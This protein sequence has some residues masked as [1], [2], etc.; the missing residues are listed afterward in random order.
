MPSETRVI[1]F[2]ISN[3]PLTHV[4]VRKRNNQFIPLQQFK[5]LKNEESNYILNRTMKIQ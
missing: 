3:I 2:M 5:R 1:I 4:L